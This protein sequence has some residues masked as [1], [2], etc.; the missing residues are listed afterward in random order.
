MMADQ[1]EEIARG[2]AE[3]AAEGLQ[4]SVDDR[5]WPRLGPYA[6]GERN[7]CHR[8]RGWRMRTLTPRCLIHRTRVDESIC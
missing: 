1:A 8:V 3:S 6:F 7:S 5:G 2:E 4:G